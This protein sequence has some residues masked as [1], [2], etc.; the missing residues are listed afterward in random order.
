MS[1]ISANIASYRF[2]SGTWGVGSS[3][4]TWYKTTIIGRG[5]DASTDEN[6]QVTNYT[7]SWAHSFGTFNLP[8]DATVLSIKCIVSTNKYWN[9]SYGG[10]FTGTLYNGDTA[11]SDTVAYCAYPSDQTHVFELKTITATTLPSIADINAGNI[12]LRNSV[13]KA[14]CGKI[15][16]ATL[17]IEY[18]GH[19]GIFNTTAPTINEGGHIA[20][21]T[22]PDINPTNSTRESISFNVS[23]QPTSWLLIC[24]GPS[25]SYTSVSNVGYYI[26][27]T[28][29]YTTGTLRA[30]CGNYYYYM[31]QYRSTTSNVTQSYNS[32]N[33]ILTLTGTSGYRFINTSKDPYTYP[34]TYYLLYNL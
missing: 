34:A 33:K 3:S 25:D 21:W 4:E 28:A 13:P 22:S 15:F 27:V 10:Q 18:L 7:V 23:G 17:Y 5:Y 31:R 30:V 19:N 11:I 8:S 9:N 16:G 1:T 14:T 29:E 20:V 32:T 24:A 26:V 12:E 6:Y 2:I